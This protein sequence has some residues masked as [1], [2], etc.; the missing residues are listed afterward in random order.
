MNFAKFKRNDALAKLDPVKRET[1]N[2]LDDDQARRMI[3]EMMRE[4]FKFWF[5]NN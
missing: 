5:W 3:A 2:K 4:Q 1:M